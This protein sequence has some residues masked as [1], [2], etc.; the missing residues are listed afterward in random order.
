MSNVIDFNQARERRDA[1]RPNDLSS[2]LRQARLIAD[3]FPKTDQEGIS[4]LS[5]D[6]LQKTLQARMAQIILERKLVGSD[7]FLCSI[8]VAGLLGNLVR[9]APESWWAIDYLATDDQIILKRGGDVCFIICGVF[10]E[11]GRRRLMDISYYQ[12]MGPAFYYRLYSV[13]GKEIGFHMSRN[14]TVMTDLAREC[15]NNL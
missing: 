4:V 14:F 3:K 6:H 2:L 11:R 8:Y 10:P 13:G 15:L 9:S 7:I 12:S 1:L 5:E